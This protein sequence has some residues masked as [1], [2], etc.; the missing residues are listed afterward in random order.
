MTSVTAPN[1]R[2]SGRD[3]LNQEHA[4]RPFRSKIYNPERPVVSQ[5]TLATLRAPQEH[6]GDQR[7]G[8]LDAGPAFGGHPGRGLEQLA[9]QE[10]QFVHGEVAAEGAV[11]EASMITSTARSWM[12]P[13]DAAVRALNTSG[14]AVLFA[15]TTVCIALLGMLVLRRANWWLPGWLDRILPHLSIEPA[16]PPAWSDGLPS[17][18]V[19]DLTEPAPAGPADQRQRLPGRRLNAE[20]TTGV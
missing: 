7:G 19:H 3:K 12:P 6:R 18:A 17:T 10:A 9:E 20:T 4:P 2:V 5:L 14:R 1:L 13:P 16:T 8:L 11:V 15:G